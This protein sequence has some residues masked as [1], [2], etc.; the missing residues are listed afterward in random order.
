[1]NLSNNYQHKI[2]AY[3]HCD[4][5]VGLKKATEIINSDISKHRFRPFFGYNIFVEKIK[6]L[7]SEEYFSLKKERPDG[8]IFINDSKF[9]IKKIKNRPIKYASHQDSCIYSNFACI[10]EIPYEEEIRKKGLH[11]TVC[12]YRKNRGSNY[13]IAAEAFSYIKPIENYIV[14]TFD[15]RSFFDNIDHSLLKD[16]VFDLLNKESKKYCS[17]K[18]I[19]SILKSLCQY[20]YIDLDENITDNTTVK[21]FINDRKLHGYKVAFEID[22]FRELCKNR[23]IT[24]VNKYSHG[25]PQGSAASA[26]LSNIYLLEFDAKLQSALKKI[27]GI[28][29]RYSDDIFIAFP[30]NYNSSRDEINTLIELELSQLKLEIQK[31]KT[32]WYNIPESFRKGKM[33]NY[34]GFSFNGK[35]I[36]IRESSLNRYFL[37]MKRGVNRAKIRFKEYCTRKNPNGD[38]MYTSN[39]LKRY[40]CS[41]WV[42]PKRKFKR[43]TKL[44]YSENKNFITYAHSSNIEF[45]RNKIRTKIRKQIRNHVKIFNDLF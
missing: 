15:I 22:E 6:K 27:N 3:I 32:C 14:G 18:E 21:T 23:I 38:K 1:M 12:A 25:I 2:K 31:E 29:R 5:P 19:S 26:I 8:I 11:L 39:L 45:H 33:I 37:K 36:Y 41:I 40:T 13:K 34:L 28:Y 20:S 9:L 16:K 35:Y 43:G 4:F 24:K 7:K 44:Y 10:L 42:L 30:A 17:N